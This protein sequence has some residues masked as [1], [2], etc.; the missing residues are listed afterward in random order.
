MKIRC[1]NQNLTSVKIAAIVTTSF[2]IK[3]VVTIGKQLAVDIKPVRLLLFFSVFCS[4]FGAQKGSI[5]SQL[6]DG[7]K[8]MHRQCILHN[9]KLISYSLKDLTWHAMESKGR[10]FLNKHCSPFDPE[11]EDLYSLL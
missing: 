11:L 6:C 4:S 1:E 9:I 3:L 8:A 10:H 2:C 5:F 7:S